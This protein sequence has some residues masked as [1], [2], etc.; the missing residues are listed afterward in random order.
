[1]NATLK[2]TEE[3]DGAVRAL[4]SIGLRPHPDAYEK[5]WD[6]WLAI[7]FI[8]TALPKNAPILDA[9]ARWS[10]I[11]QRLEALGYSELW[12][13]DLRRSARET[14]WRIVRRSKIR[15]LE[16]DLTRAP[17]PDQTFAAVTC[18]SVIEH[19]VKPEDYFR[20]MSRIL[21]PGGY[22]ITSTDYWCQP[23]DTN[24]IFP[25]GPAFGEMTIFDP[26]GIRK[27]VRIANDYGLQL[28][29]PLELECEDKVVH[30]KRV[31]RRYTFIFFV[32]QRR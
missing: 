29:E 19:G 25:Y 24:G 23:V 15:F 21:K 20:E 7:D 9:G 1:M 5:N 14:L 10:P 32:L 22:L 12:G 8:K 28:T 30:W 18:V 17:F 3:I 27:L 31:D 4:R 2:R 11:L 6:L 16:A 26:D 13:C